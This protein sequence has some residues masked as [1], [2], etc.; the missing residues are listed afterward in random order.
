M[1]AVQSKPISPM[2][3]NSVKNCCTNKN[4]QFIYP[5]CGKNGCDGMM[6]VFAN[7]NHATEQHSNVS[8][9]RTKRYA[10]QIGQKQTHK[11]KIG[12]NDRKKLVKIQFQ[13]TVFA[14]IFLSK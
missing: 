1:N 13:S 12:Y 6:C 5:K 7:Q 3:V 9:F 11:T 2:R 14:S 10:V 8:I 4:C